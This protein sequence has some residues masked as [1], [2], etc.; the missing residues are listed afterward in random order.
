MLEDIQF[1]IKDKIKNLSIDLHSNIVSI[2]RHFHQNPELSF[3]EFETSKYIKH[4][5]K[6]NNIQYDDSFDNTSVIGII[7]GSHKGETIAL[8]AD[9]DAL[10]INENTNC[11]YKSNNPSVMHACGH[12]AHAA[13]LL[14]TAIILEKLK[15]YINGRI[16]LIFQHAEELNPGG[17]IELI[18]K[19]LIKKYNISKI[20]AQHVLPELETGKICISPGYVMAA[21]D[22][23]YI[24][25][26]GIGGHAALPHKRSDVILATTEFINTINQYQIELQKEN[27]L[28]I[29]FGKII[30]EGA[31]NVLPDTANIEGT[32]RTF[33]DN[34]R[35]KIQDKIL[36]TANDIAI[37]YKSTAEVY[38]SKGYPSVYN[39]P[40][41]VNQIIIAATNYL[42]KENVEQMAIRMTAEDFA[43][44]GKIIPAAFYR[45]GIQGNN[46]GNIGL[47][48]PNFDID[49]D[50]FYHSIGLMAYIAI[51][52]N[53]NNN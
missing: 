36:K 8:R 43:H 51:Y 7:N 44:Y 28:I 9:I 40:Q 15:E 33:D 34:L 25:F 35:L 5:L 46:K 41:L 11:D 18:N 29:A 30:A 37:K 16:I 10:R 50:V 13:S 19:G 38:I 48:N 32:M 45:I 23:L 24:K 22:E 4:I 39:D 42:N 20:I 26:S 17:A 3:Q 53:Y 49:E 6:E 21:S 52:L 31:V 1:N 27:N 12:D 14:G 47:H 2:R